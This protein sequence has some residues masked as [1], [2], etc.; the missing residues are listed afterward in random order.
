MKLIRILLPLWLIFGATLAAR[1]AENASVHAILISAS[2]EPGKTDGRLSQYEPTLKRILRFE[3]YR[4]LGQ[5][6]ATLRNDRPS[7][8]S[9]GEGQSLRLSSEEPG[10][11]GVRVKVIW[12]NG[13]RTLMETGLSL[14]PG[15]PAV[16]G[17]PGTGKQGEVYA[18]IL[19]GR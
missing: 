1:A 12:E 16:L 4:F 8:I 15:A 17:G 18:I 14:R 7:H 13:G 19:I 3:S 10:K 6:T 11:H 2:N 5:G 9:L